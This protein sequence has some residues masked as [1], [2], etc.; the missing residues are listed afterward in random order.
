MKK[1]TVQS[2]YKNPDKFISQ[3]KTDADTHNRYKKH[4]ENRIEE[5]KKQ[6]IGL[7]S[8]GQK[9]LWFTYQEPGPKLTAII[10]D[11]SAVYKLGELDIGSPIYCIGKVTKISRSEDE[12]SAAFRIV[13]VY[14]R[15]EE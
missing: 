4:L 15:R 13:S 9:E 2:S 1:H 8:F 3:L 7:Q 12:N 6:I 10:R 5:L 11:Y 14:T